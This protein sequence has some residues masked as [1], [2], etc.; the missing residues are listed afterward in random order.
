MRLPAS[1]PVS[2]VLIA[3]FAYQAPWRILRRTGP[4]EP[5]FLG[6][7]W[8]LVR[9]GVERRVGIGERPDDPGRG[10]EIGIARMHAEPGRG[11][12]QVGNAGFD[13]HGALNPAQ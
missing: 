13:E 9:G 3:V 11:L 5:P 12:A 2:R 8:N 4:R 7:D 10:L 6:D 1:L